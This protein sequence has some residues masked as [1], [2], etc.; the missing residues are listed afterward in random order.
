[1]VNQKR[2]LVTGGAGYVG[3]ALVPKL[4][5]AGY[6][7]NVLDLYIY[8]DHIFGD[9]SASPHLT[10]TSGHQHAFLIYHLLTYNHSIKINFE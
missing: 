10:R 1:M 3:S 9:Y 4:I 7:V 8:G 6:E 5:D 2:V